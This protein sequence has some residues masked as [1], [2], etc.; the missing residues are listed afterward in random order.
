MLAIREEVDYRV[1]YMAE[2]QFD[3]RV[4]DVYIAKQ[5]TKKAP[6]FHEILQELV[7]IEACLFVL[8]REEAFSDLTEDGRRDLINL[9]EAEDM[10]ALD[11][12]LSR[13]DARFV[14]MFAKDL[15]LYLVSNQ[16]SFFEQDP[17][18]KEHVVT[19]NSS[20]QSVW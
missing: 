5:T 20:I 7:D 11:F 12:V 8:H 16:Y 3:E 18:D 14:E 10:G 17:W 9:I 2:R 19:H 6:T 13:L 1:I 4:R 15:F